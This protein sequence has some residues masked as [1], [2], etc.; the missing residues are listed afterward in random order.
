MVEAIVW[1]RPL[2]SGEA[3]TV[4]GHII[5]ES[6]VEQVTLFRGKNFIRSTVR[7]DEIV[8]HEHDDSQPAMKTQRLFDDLQ[9]ARYVA[10]SYEF[11]GVPTD[12]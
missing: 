2:K 6:D 7:R 3:D 4:I 11:P 12:D 8:A 1:E 10:L 5:K 9:K